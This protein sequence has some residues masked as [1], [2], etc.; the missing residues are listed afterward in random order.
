MP[1]NIVKPPS[2]SINAIAVYYATFSLFEIPLALH[3]QS[4]FNYF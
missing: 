3:L 4:N 1:S 2:K